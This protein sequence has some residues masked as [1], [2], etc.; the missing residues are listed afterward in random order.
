[1]GCFFFLKN[2]LFLPLQILLVLFSSEE[3][4]E[5]LGKLRFTKARLWQ[6]NQC[7]VLSLPHSVYAPHLNINANATPA[8]NVGTL[9][10]RTLLHQHA[11]RIAILARFYAALIHNRFDPNSTQI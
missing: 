2:R 6:A 3:K 10:A 4:K 9:V 11:P 1:M 7:A 8:P 5:D